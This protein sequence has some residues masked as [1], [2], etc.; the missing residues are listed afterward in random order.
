MP[1]VIP[2]TLPAE[3]ELAPCQYAVDITEGDPQER[4]YI[5]F[6][7][8][9]GFTVGL[10]QAQPFAERITSYPADEFCH[11]V[12]GSVTLTDTG[13]AARTFR[14]G[15]A[16]TV[17]AGWAGEWR[18]NEPFMKYFVLSAPQPATQ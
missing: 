18:V 8:P 14:A 3:S 16:F 9:G 13:G 1:S 15:D 2:V 11:V 4:E 12:R 10:W 6:A 17:Q 5:Y 7:A